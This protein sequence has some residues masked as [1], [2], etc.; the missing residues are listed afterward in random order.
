[1]F[2]RF[3][4]HRPPTY[5]GANDP[6]ALEAWI[7]EIEKL[8]LATGCPE[9]Q[10]VNIAT[11][12]LKDEAENWWALARAAMDEQAYDR[13]LSIYDSVLAIEADESAKS[14]FV[15]RP[16]VTPYASQ[17][18]QKFEARSSSP[19]VQGQAKKDWS[20][21][22]CGNAYHPGK[23]CDG[24]V[25]TCYLCKSPG[26]KAVDCPQKPKTDAPKTSAPKAD[27]PKTGRVFVMS[28][29]EADANPDVKIVLKSPTGSRVSYQGVRVTSTVKWVSALKMVSLSR[30]GYQIY[31]CSVHGV[32]VEPKLEDIPVIRAVVDWESPK[33]VNEVQS[34][35]GL[36]GYYRRFVHD[37]SKIARPMTQL[38]KKESKYIWTEA[39]EAAFQELKKRLTTAPVL[40]LPEEG[41]EFDVFCDA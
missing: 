25:L 31:L 9:D 38:M 14:K 40:T 12:Y 22:R 13:A 27:A 7:R 30:K 2:D 5:D 16:Y 36:A 37:F 41:V 29:A 15:T 1:M 24:N 17:K 32:L 33:N 21:F 6:T 10:M 3:A 28:R 20:C 4:H 39:C 23:Y 18:K 35:L 11:Y 19:R 26:H 8:L 34:F